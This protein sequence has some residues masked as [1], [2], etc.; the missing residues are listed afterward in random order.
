[1]G[2]R[3]GIPE[4]LSTWAQCV[5]RRKDKPL[6][7]EQPSSSHKSLNLPSELPYLPAERPSNLTPSSS[8]ESL[9]LSGSSDCAFFQRLPFEIRRLILIEAFGN[10]TLH[11]DLIHGY[12]LPPH[13]ERMRDP[14][15]V[16][17]HAQLTWPEPAPEPEPSRFRKRKPKQ[18]EQWRWQGCVCHDFPFGICNNGPW[19]DNCRIGVI[20]PGP[21]TFEELEKGDCDPSL[22]R[23]R[24]SSCFLSI[25]GWL[26][27]CKQ[28]SVSRFLWG[29]TLPFH[30]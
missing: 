23:S 28:A 21:W 19:N 25:M 3:W 13:S 17:R 9:V 6:H 15:L 29:Q 14:K 16:P 26:L 18:V 5:R 12:P 11:M 22:D 7:L 30:N 10:Y 8:Q 24:R 20:G 27:S 2:E 4:R 1:M